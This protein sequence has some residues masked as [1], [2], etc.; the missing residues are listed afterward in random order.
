MRGFVIG[1]LAAF[2]GAALFPASE[3]SAQG[4]GGGLAAPSLVSEAA[5]VTERI[6][7]PRGVRMVRRCGPGVGMGRPHMGMGGGMGMGGCRVIKERVMT[8]R[9]MVVR[10]TRRC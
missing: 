4:L 1:A 7:G 6:E 2:A 10:T 9:G 5:C 3:A 8:P